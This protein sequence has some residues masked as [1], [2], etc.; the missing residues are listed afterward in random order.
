ML[1]K[2]R[3]LNPALDIFSVD[4][5]AFSPYGRVLK[6]YDFSKMTAYA[7][8]H[9]DMPA[10]GTAYIRSDSGLETIDEI[11]P[12]EKTVYG[13][14]PLQAGWCI[15]RN[16]RMNAMEFHKGNEVNIA[17]TDLFLLLG[18]AEDI[19]DNRYDAG[20]V[21]GFFVPKGQAVELYAPTLHFA[22]VNVGKEPFIAIVILPKGTNAPFDGDRPVREG[23][24]LLFAVNKWMICHPDSPQAGRGAVQGI[25]GVNITVKTF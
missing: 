14:M 23:D 7:L 4:D 10:D 12:L 19:R 18:K 11:R 1:S 6:G 21:T 9:A 16:N 24:E 22:P 20:R 17:V 25:T 15:G 3:S 5:P 13:G 8:S 2:L